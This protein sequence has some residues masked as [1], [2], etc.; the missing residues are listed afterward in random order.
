MDIVTT[1]SDDFSTTV[2][3]GT[4]AVVKE[5]R[6]FVM[7]D[8]SVT[9][10]DCSDCTEITDVDATDSSAVFVADFRVSKVCG[11]DISI[12][13]TGDSKTTAGDSLVSERPN[14]LTGCSSAIVEGSES[15]FK[16]E[17]DSKSM[18]PS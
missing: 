4:G 12:D 16:K 9:A 13:T 18:F 15:N 11:S 3:V 8:S 2:V 6:I 7:G 10:T 14:T 5:S 1:G 17:S